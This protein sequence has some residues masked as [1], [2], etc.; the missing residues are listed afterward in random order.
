VPNNR[1]ILP[2]IRREIDKAHAAGI[3][4][5][6]V[7]DTHAPDD[8]EFSKFGWPPHGVKGTRGAQVVDELK[9]SEGD[10]IVEKT[11]YS[12]FDGT[13]LDEI[14]ENFGI[15]S[16]RLTGC[17]TNICIMFG[18][19]EA[20]LRGYEVTAIEDGIAGLDPKDHE[21]ALRNMKN[22]LRVKIE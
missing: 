2:N 19:Y 13:P 21:A 18:A 17:V 3:P 14:L 16:I 10:I 9:P 11:S 4:V 5:I 20:E 12:L 8:R 7:C 1:K 22:V 6:Y 15:D